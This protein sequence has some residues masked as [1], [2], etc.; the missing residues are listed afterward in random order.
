MDREGPLIDPAMSFPDIARYANPVDEIPS[1][2]A[3]AHKISLTVKERRTGSRM[4]F[5]GYPS[6]PV[7][8]PVRW[9]GHMRPVG[10]VLPGGLLQAEAAV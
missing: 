1:N 2:M 3:C 8:C 6:T 9:R 7:Q 4:A 5:W 10:V